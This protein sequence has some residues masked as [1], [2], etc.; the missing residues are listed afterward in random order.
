MLLPALL[1]A[2]AAGVAAP[3]RSTSDTVAYA[4]S[5]VIVDGALRAL[6]VEMRLDGD[7]DGETRI[8][9]PDEW[10]GSDSLWRRLGRVEVA[11]GAVVDAG[12]PAARLVRHAP[13]APLVVRYEVRSAWDTAPGFAWRKALPLVLGDWFF[14]HGEGVFATPGGRERAPATFAWRGWP[15]AWRLASDLDHLAGARPGTVTDVVESVAIGAPDLVLATR[16]LDGAPL[17]VATRG[18]WRFAPDAFTDAVARIVAA[19]NAQWGDRAAPFLV[20]LAPLGGATSGYS[21]TGTSRA[22]AFSIGS[23]PGTALEDA[24]RLLAHEYQHTWTPGALGGSPVR[25]EATGFWFSEG[26]T[27]WHAARTMLAAGLWSFDDYVAELNRVLLRDATSPARGTPAREIAGRFWSDRAVQQLPYD[28]GHLVA[29]ALGRELARRGATLRAVLDAQRRRA[30]RGGVDAPALFPVVLRE[31]TG[32]DADGALARWT[33]D[34]EPLLLPPDLLAPCA[35]VVTTSQPGFSRGFDLDATNRSG[36]VL[37][38]VDSTSPA[39]AAGLRDGL[40]IVR[41]EAGVTGDASVALA[42]RVT[43]G[44]TERVVRYLPEGKDRVTVQRVVVRPG[45]DEAACARMVGG[46]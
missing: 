24:L 21:F 40:R 42:Y 36:G 28:R 26:F 32:L 31:T 6:A 37:A 38:G 33:R 5:P 12:T 19:T 27:D 3:S 2:L 1:L 34:G 11:G 16:T 41:R 4:V 20:V 18:A 13:G 14:V 44:T 29:L 30:R 22:D 35:T 25:D 17:R 45:A 23:T 7:A 43:D 15:A 39:W 10:A 8:D 9:L 46:T